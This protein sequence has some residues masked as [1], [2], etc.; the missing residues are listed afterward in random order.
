MQSRPLLL[1]LYLVSAT[2]SCASFGRE[3][4]FTQAD[5]LQPGVS[6]R[7]D[8]EKLL[9]KPNSVSTGSNGMTVCVWMYS[10]ANSFTGKSEA[11]SLSLVFG[12]DGKLVR[13][14]QST[15]N[16]RTS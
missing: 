4:D 7:A 11:Q 13:K 8:A 14:N 9:G 16:G 3:I 10:H 6:T 12:A 1:G 15:M 5:K 2:I